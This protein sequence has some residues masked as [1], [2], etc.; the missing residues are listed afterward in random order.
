EVPVKFILEDPESLTGSDRTEWDVLAAKGEHLLE[1]AV[2]NGINI[3]HACGGVCACSTCHV[4]VEQGMDD[5]AEATEAEEDRVEEAPGLQMNSRL[6]CQCEV[7]GNGPIVVR[8]PAWNRNAVKEAAAT[9]PSAAWSAKPA[10]SKSFTVIPPASWVETVSVTLERS[11]TSASESFSIVPHSIQ[12]DFGDPQPSEKTRLAPSPTGALHLGNARTFVV[13]WI[14]ARQQGWGIVMRIEDLDGP[15]VKPGSVEQTLETMA[16]L[17]L[18]W[19]Q[20][21]IIQSHDLEPHVGAMRTLASSALAYPCDL[22]RSEIAEAASAPH[23]GD[24]A[25]AS[26]ARPRPLA[27]AGFTDRETNWRFATPEGAIEIN[28][29]FLGAT[30]TNPAVE[31]GDFV[32]WTKRGMP[33]YQL[34][35]VVDDARQSVT[36]VVRGDDLLDS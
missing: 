1:I 4:Y 6:S 7:E 24:G 27:P 35:V 33:A 23:A 5:V 22:T 8:V 19:D 34:A 12:P 32:V 2:D 36:R 3:E 14:L 21:P 20:G 9:M 13:N 28:D 29:A 18:D 25:P 17:G 10:R 30:T 31:A 26:I 15:R 16:W 11:F